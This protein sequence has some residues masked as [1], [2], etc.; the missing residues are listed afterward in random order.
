MNAPGKFDRPDNWADDVVAELISIYADQGQ[1]A[2][3]AH[4]HAIVE[5]DQPLQID[6]NVALGRF[7]SIIQ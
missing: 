4:W 1:A 2:A 3:E 7:K 5:R 6:A